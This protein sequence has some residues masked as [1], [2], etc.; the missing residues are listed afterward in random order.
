MP[1]D[2]HGESDS[3]AGDA[4]SD[5]GWSSDSDQS[6][7]ASDEDPTTFALRVGTLNAH[8]YQRKKTEVLATALRHKV[9]VLAH[10]ETGS[11]TQGRVE[12][13]DYNLWESGANRAD[14]KALLVHTGGQISAEPEAMTE[15]VFV[16]AVRCR[17][18]DLIPVGVVYATPN[19]AEREVVDGVQHVVQRHSGPLVLLGDFNKNALRRPAYQN[20]LRTWGHMAYPTGWTWTCSTD[21]S[22][23][24][25]RTAGKRTLEWGVKIAQIRMHKCMV[26]AVKHLFQRVGMVAIFLQILKD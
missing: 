14:G 5:G 23:H 25:L 20:R 12:G 21:K 2:D 10:T 18:K 19:R 6:H 15:D 16:L 8:G 24:P 22:V 11:R 3:S 7:A 26:S 1:S 13:E 9:D 4:S 17:E